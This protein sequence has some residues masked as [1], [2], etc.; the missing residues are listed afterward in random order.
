MIMMKRKE[1]AGRWRH[2]DS[3]C[4]F[5]F[6]FSCHHV[7]TKQTKKKNNCDG[8]PDSD[9]MRMGGERWAQSTRLNQQ[10]LPAEEQ[11]QYL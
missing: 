1:G 4:W 11:L 2:D 7:T 3:C 9:K 10:K 8:G 6:S 5:G